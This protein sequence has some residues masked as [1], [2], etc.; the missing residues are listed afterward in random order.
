MR[1]TSRGSLLI[2]LSTALYL[3]AYLRM[4]LE[5]AVSSSLLLFYILYRHLLFRNTLRKVRLNLTRWSPEEV[6]FRGHT[7]TLYGV[8][9]SNIP[10]K[11]LITQEI[12][13]NFILKEGVS[14]VAGV[15]E[16]GKPVEFKLV[17]QAVKRGRATLPPPQVEIR[18]GAGIMVH[19][20]VAGD[21]ISLHVH[22]SWQDVLR[23]KAVATR[24]EMEVRG[25]LELGVEGLRGD[26]KKIRDWTP[27]D[28]LRD[29]AWKASSRLQKLL[30]KEFEVEVE[31]PV[32]VAL[33]VSR[34]MRDS[35]RVPS[36][37]DHALNIT[38]QLA[39]IFDRRGQPFGLMLYD[40]TRVIRYLRPRRGSFDLVLTEL[41]L[42][43]PPSPPPS[44]LKRERGG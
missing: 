6:A 7:L 39:A 21:P 42:L 16:P 20:T 41:L 30:T 27:G 10:L 1:Y 19:E 11:V 22:A 3:Y 14:R 5:I 12:P 18:E 36:K 35:I 44:L 32:V 24:S 13:D 25:T 29:V 37:L 43:P 34:G 23:A 9:E 26:L 33:D 40:E 38:L 2:L 15:A 17:L 31:V 28:R 4:S 8:L